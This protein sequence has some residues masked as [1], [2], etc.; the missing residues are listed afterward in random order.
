MGCGTGILAILSEMR[1]AKSVDAIDIDNWCY[2]NSLE[3]V[4][5]N[6]C[7]N[8][9][10]FEGHVS[11]I[12]NSEYDIILANINRNILLKDIPYYANSLNKCGELYLSGFYDNDLDLIISKCEENGLIFVDKL[13]KNDWISAKFKIA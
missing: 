6:K 13:K 12:E 8:I 5:R 2:L 3:N 11:L 7:E 1:G 4:E 10:V 9:R